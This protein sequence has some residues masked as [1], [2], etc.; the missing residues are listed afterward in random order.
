MTT[1]TG[2]RCGHCQGRHDS[3]DAVRACAAGSEIWPC[4]WL[5]R[6]GLDED[7]GHIIRECG[8]ESWEMPAG[9]GYECAAGH[10]HVSME[11][12]WAEGWDYAS[13]AEEATV[14]RK[15]GIDAVGPD[16]GSI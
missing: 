8:A 15:N 2:I 9:R 16:G 4:T 1:S 11:A 12:R 10:S 5:V 13:D 3:V 14:M 7:G 6:V